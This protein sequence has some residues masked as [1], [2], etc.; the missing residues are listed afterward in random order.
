M[1][2]NKFVKGHLA[3]D[4]VK[5]MMMIYGDPTQANIRKPLKS[6]TEM[7]FD[8]SRTSNKL[9]A[10][11]NTLSVTADN[12]AKQDGSGAAQRSNSEMDTKKDGRLSQ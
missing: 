3:A 10:K 7:G 12:F 5:A 2:R 4:H 9:A 11:T 6:H 8:S 1:P